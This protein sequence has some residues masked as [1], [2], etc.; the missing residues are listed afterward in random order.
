MVSV[1]EYIDFKPLKENWNLYLLEENVLL[2]MR[3]VLIKVMLKD[4]DEV[5]N[6]GYEINYHAV[7]GIVPPP[8][9]VGE[10]LERTYTKKEIMDSIVK[11]DVKVVKTIQ[12]EWNKYKLEDGATLNI[13]LI[14]TK[15]SKTS[16]FDNRGEPIYNVHHQVIMK[17]TVPTELRQEY[18]ERYEKLLKK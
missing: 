10:P 12:E 17:G 9:L 2:K 13:K 5:G 16:L 7:I 14:L 18:R 4:I 1:E 6:P 15:A 8:D 3:F 11:D